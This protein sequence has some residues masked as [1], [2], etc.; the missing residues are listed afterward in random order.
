VEKRK[1]EAEN[2]MKVQTST[3]RGGEG[4]TNKKGR[5]FNFFSNGW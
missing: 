1:R 2:G 3:E 5:E 4:D